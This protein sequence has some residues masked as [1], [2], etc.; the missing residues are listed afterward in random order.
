[1][2][3]KI[4]YVSD[5]HLEY[6]RDDWDPKKFIP[7]DCTENDVLILAGDIGQYQSE[8]EG[9]IFRFL[10]SVVPKFAAVIYVPGNHEFWGNI[11]KFE[12]D[13]GLRNLCNT[14]GVHYLNQDIVTIN[15]RICILGCTLWSYISPVMESTMSGYL[16]DNQNIPGWSPAR[17]RSE[18]LNN[19]SWLLTNIR[20]LR[21][22]YP[23]VIVV[24]H[25]APLVRHT[26]KPEYEFDPK[27]CGYCSDC[28]DVV[29][30]ANYWIFGHTHHSTQ[31]EYKGCK[32]IANQLG[33]PEEDD[34]GFKF[35]KN[36]IC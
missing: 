17:A 6:R 28:S 12:A 35:G 4:Y 8:S 33:K 11:Q 24:T 26:S 31:L 5:L 1:M 25:H 20:S 9:V 29:K 7:V 27:N 34:T 13:N 21:Q 10:K 30:L 32:V 14:L 18:F 22:K 36:F 15:G 16:R 2:P 23:L 3:V 19:R